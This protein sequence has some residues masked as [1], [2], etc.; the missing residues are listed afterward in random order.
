MKTI[1][2]TTATRPLS[3]Y[4]RELEDE[5]VVLTSHQEPVAALIS[6][7]GIDKES[8][9]LSTDPEFIAIIERARA[10][11]AAGKKLTLDEMKQSL[12]SANRA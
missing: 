10:E 5:V 7:K 3:E 2:L 9:I 8:L 6:L 4:A 1:E 12:E 11:F